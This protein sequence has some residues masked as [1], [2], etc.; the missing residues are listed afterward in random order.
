MK[1]NLK[2]NQGPLLQIRDGIVLNLE[3]NDTIFIWKGISKIKYSNSQHEF[4]EKNSYMIFVGNCY[5]YT[6]LYM[7]DIHIQ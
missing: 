5:K 6:N 2:Y 7:L 1:V 4:L 3:K